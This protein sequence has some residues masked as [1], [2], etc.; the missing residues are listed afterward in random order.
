MKVSHVRRPDKA[1]T[2]I[3]AVLVVIAVALSLQAF[4]AYQLGTHFDDARYIIL[5]RSLITS[6]QYGGIHLAGQPGIPWYPFGYPLLLTPFVLQF[7]ENLEASKLLSLAATV[8]NAALLFWGW[9]WYSRRSHW[10]AVAVVALYAFA[11]LSIDLTRRVMSEPF[12]LTV[13]LA[14]LL[15]TEQAAQGKKTR[16]W[17]F[18][19]GVTLTF[20]LFVR[21]IGVVLIACAFAYLLFRTRKALWKE[22]LLTV[23]TMVV[24]LG[25]VVALTPV[26][27]GSLV[28]TFYLKSYEDM[29]TPLLEE[30][31]EPE[32]GSA[33]PTPLSHE[34]DQPVEGSPRIDLSRFVDW[35]V[36]GPLKQHLGK[37][38]RRAILPIGGGVREQ[39][40]ADRLGLPF[41]PWLVGFATF[42]LVAVGCFR[43]LRQEG[44][45]A[46]N[47]FAVVYFGALF[48][49]VWND[50][51][52]LYPI[53]PQL[54]YAFLLGIEAIFALTLFRHR[55]GLFP[56][57]GKAM[58]VSIFLVLALVSAY[59][60]LV[61]DDSRLHA[62]DMQLR[63]SWLKAN[64]PPSAIVMTEAPEIDYIYHGRKTVRYPATPASAGE[65]ANFLAEHSVDYIL[66][67]PE[68]GW[69]VSYVPTYSENTVNMLPLIASLVSE[70]RMT[71]VYSSEEDWIK[72]FQVLPQD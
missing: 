5:A 9:P 12:F 4:D 56:K 18:L 60:S 65:L 61:I 45:S 50:P 10:W 20:V 31:P 24:L 40:F 3:W 55:K 57:L 64:T 13:C 7:P 25:F 32:T 37:D 62:G 29:S 53:L 52:L 19:M 72:V 66:V 11:P 14:A 28:P 16:G 69:Q 1:Q 43:W 41:L 48:L 67:A 46:F 59:K 44:L 36:I 70:G 54:Q 17:S 38:V 30:V 42:G 23:T 47:L 34:V 15:L 35:V 2:A 26:E 63:C 33:D 22:L 68:T 39:A 27:L 58:M 51:R 49:W 6:D 21:T 8:A 71:L